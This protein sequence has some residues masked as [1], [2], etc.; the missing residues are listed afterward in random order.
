MSS[1]VDDKE[2]SPR[3]HPAFSYS[4]KQ[5]EPTVPLEA[6]SHWKNKTLG[7]ERL[8][9]TRDSDGTVVAK[10]LTQGFLQ[11]IASFF[12]SNK[13]DN[14][15]M[16]KD[17]KK[18]QHI[19]Q[20]FFEL[21]VLKMNDLYHKRNSLKQVLQELESD[22]KT[23]EENSSE[24]NT[25]LKP[26][27]DPSEQD[28]KHKPLAENNSYV[29]ELPNFELPK[30]SDTEIEERKRAITAMRKELFSLAKQIQ[31][32]ESSPEIKVYTQLQ[33][34]LSNVKKAA[35]SAFKI[36]NNLE[37][38]K[39]DPNSSPDLQRAMNDV[40]TLY[41]NFDEGV[42]RTL[43]EKS[44]QQQIN[45]FSQYVHLFPEELQA[46]WSEFL[47]ILD[48][49]PSSEA[50][51]AEVDGMIHEISKQYSALMSKT[52]SE[53]VKD[54]NIRKEILETQSSTKDA[55]VLKAEIHLKQAICESRRD[56]WE[57]IDYENEKAGFKKIQ[58]LQELIKQQQEVDKLFVRILNQE[59][60]V[61][62]LSKVS[63]SLSY[64]VAPL[65]PLFTWPVKEGLLAR[66]K[67]YDTTSLL[68]VEQAKEKLLTEIAEFMK[69]IPD[70]P[71]KN[72]LVEKHHVP[73]F[74]GKELKKSQLDAYV[75]AICHAYANDSTFA[76]IVTRIRA[77][78][79]VLS[80]MI[81]LQRNNNNIFSKSLQDHHS[82]IFSDESIRHTAIYKFAESGKIYIETCL[83]DDINLND[84]SNEW[85]K[86]RQ[87]AA[88]KIDQLIQLQ[89]ASDLYK[90]RLI[91]N[92]QYEEQIKSLTGPEAELGRTCLLKLES[93]LHSMDAS[94]SRMDKNLLV[95]YLTNFIAVDTQLDEL[96]STQNQRKLK[97]SELNQ[98]IDDFIGSLAK[99]DKC[100]ETIEKEYSIELKLKSYLESQKHKLRELK[101]IAPSTGYLSYL[102]SSDEKIEDISLDSLLKHIKYVENEFKNIQ[103]FLDDSKIAKIPD[104]ITTFNNNYSVLKNKIPSLKGELKFYKS[105]TVNDDLQTMLRVQ[106]EDFNTYPISEYIYESLKTDIEKLKEIA[107]QIS[108]N[109][110]LSLLVQTENLLK[111]EENLKSDYEIKLAHANK[112]NLDKEINIAEEARLSLEEATILAEQA[113]KSFFKQQADRLIRH[114][115][116]MTNAAKQFENFP[117]LYQQTISIIKRT[118]A[119]LDHNIQ[120]LPEAIREHAK[121][122]TPL[123]EQGKSPLSPN[124]NLPI[125]SLSIK[126]MQAYEAAID[127]VINVSGNHL[128]NLE[129]AFQRTEKADKQFAKKL[130]DLKKRTEDLDKANQL[131][132]RE[133]LK[134]TISKFEKSN[135]EFRAEV[136][137]E[138]SQ[139]KSP[140][141]WFPIKKWFT[142][143]K[144]LSPNNW[145][146][147]IT[148]QQKREI[149]PTNAFNLMEEYCDNIG[150]AVA[151][152]E[153]ELNNSKNFA[154]LEIPDQLEQC[155]DLEVAKELQKR[156]ND[157]IKPKSD[158]VR[159]KLNT[160]LIYGE[161]PSEL[162]KYISPT[163]ELYY[164]IRKS[165]EDK[166]ASIDRFEKGFENKNIFAWLTGSKT[167][168][169]TELTSSQMKSHTRDLKQIQT[170]ITSNI[171]DT[172]FI[173]DIVEAE[174]YIEEASTIQLEAQVAKL[175][176]DGF[177]IEAYE[178][179]QKIFKDMKPSS[180]WHFKGFTW[181]WTGREPNQK[182]TSIDDLKKLKKELEKVKDSIK[183]SLSEA[184]ANAKSKKPSPLEDQLRRLIKEQTRID[185]LVKPFAIEKKQLGNFPG[186]I[187]TLRTKII[188]KATN[189]LANHQSYLKKVQDYIDKIYSS[190]KID[191][192]SQKE[193]DELIK[194]EI[195]EFAA[196]NY[197]YDTFLPSLSLSQAF[198]SPRK[199][200]AD[201]TA[202]D[203]I[204]FSPDSQISKRIAASKKTIANIIDYES[205]NKV[206]NNYEAI[207]N[208]AEETKKTL[209]NI[210]DIY[211][212]EELENE[213]DLAKNDKIHT[214]S[215]S[216]KDHFEDLLD[217]LEELANNLE[218]REIEIGGRPPMKAADQILKISNP[219][220]KEELTRF[221]AKDITKKTIQQTVLI[222]NFNEDLKK[223]SKTLPGFPKE[224]KKTITKDLNDSKTKIEEVS[225]GLVEK[226][227]WTET[228]IP[229]QDLDING[230]QKVDGNLKNEFKNANNITDK[231]HLQLLKDPLKFYQERLEA[232]EKTKAKWTKEKYFD[233]VEELNQLIKKIDGDFKNHFD[234]A[235]LDNLPKEMLNLID[236]ISVKTSE[237]IDGLEKI[238]DKK[239]KSWGE[240]VQTR[241][242]LLMQ[243]AANPTSDDCKVAKQKFDEAITEFRTETKTK[244]ETHSK[245]IDEY[246]QQLDSINKTVQSALKVDIPAMWKYNAKK[247]IEQKKTQ[248]N[249]LIKG[250]P[251]IGEKGVTWKSF[252]MISQQDPKVA[253]PELK[254]YGKL[255]SSIAE[256]DEEIKITPNSGLGNLKHLFKFDQIKSDLDKF[257]QKS[258]DITRIID[259]SNTAN[260]SKLY[261]AAALEANTKLLKSSLQSME[262]PYDIQ[263]FTRTLEI[264]L[265]SVRRAYEEN[266]VRENAFVGENKLDPWSYIVHDEN[267]NKDLYR[268]QTEPRVEYLNQ[269][270][271]LG[272]SIT[273]NQNVPTLNVD[274][275]KTLTKNEQD[276]IATNKLQNETLLYELIKK[277]LSPNSITAKEIGSFITS[278]GPKLNDT[279]RSLEI[280]MVTESGIMPLPAIKLFA[281]L[282]EYKKQ[283]DKAVS[284]AEQEKSKLSNE[285]NTIFWFN[286]L[287]KAEQKHSAEDV[288]A[289]H[290][291][292]VL[293]YGNSNEP[294]QAPTVQAPVVPSVQP[295]VLPVFNLP[296]VRAT[297]ERGKFLIEEWKNKA[298]QLLT[299]ATMS[300]NKNSLVSTLRTWNNAEI[301]KD[302]KT[303]GKNLRDAFV[304]YVDQQTCTYKYSLKIGFNEAINGIIAKIEDTTD[305]S[306]V[307]QQIQDN[308]SMDTIT[309]IIDSLTRVQSRLDDLHNVFENLVILN[310]QTSSIREKI[311]NVLA[312]PQAGR[313]DDLNKQIEEAQKSLRDLRMPKLSNE[314]E[315]FN[316]NLLVLKNKLT[317]IN[318]DFCFY[319]K[320][321]QETPNLAR[322]VEVNLSTSEVRKAL[323]SHLH[324]P[325][326][327]LEDVNKKREHLSNFLDSLQTSNVIQ[328]KDNFSL[329]WKKKLF[330]YI[331]NLHQPNADQIYQNLL[332][333]KAI[334]EEID[335]FSQKFKDILINIKEIT[336]QDFSNYFATQENEIKNFKNRILLTDNDKLDEYKK[337]IT[338]GLKKI[339]AEL[340]IE[341]ITK[342]LQS[343]NNVKRDISS[344]RDRFRQDKHYLQTQ[345]L[346][347]VLNN[348]TQTQTSITAFDQLLKM[349]PNIPYISYTNFNEIS[350]KIEK[351]TKEL[352]EK[353]ESINKSPIKKTDVSQ[354]MQNASETDEEFINFKKEMLGKIEKEIL[355]IE[356]S[357]DFVVTLINSNQQ[358]PWASFLKEPVD[359]EIK[360]FKAQIN[361]INSPQKVGF[362]LGNPIP[363][364][365]LKPNQFFE[366]QQVALE[367]LKTA[368][369]RIKSIEN[370]CKTIHLSQTQLDDFENKTAEAKDSL[371]KLSIRKIRNFYY[372]KKIEVTHKKLKELGE[373]FKNFNWVAANYYDYVSPII[374]TAKE[375]DELSTLYSKILDNLPE[376][377]VTE[378]NQLKAASNDPLVKFEAND[379][380]FQGIK[381]S[382]QTRVNIALNKLNE[383]LS[384]GTFEDFNNHPQIKDL[385]IKAIKDKIS[386]VG[387]LKKDETQIASLNIDELAAWLGKIIGLSSANEAPQNAEKIDH[388]ADVDTVF[389]RLTELRKRSNKFKDALKDC[390]MSNQ[391]LK[392]KAAV[393]RD[394]LPRL[395]IEINKK[396]DQVL[397]IPVK[398]S[399]DITIDKFIDDFQI[400][401][402]KKLYKDYIDLTNQSKH[403]NYAGNIKIKAE[404][405][406]RA[407]MD[408]R[409]TMSLDAFWIQFDL[410]KINLQTNLRTNQMG[411][412]LP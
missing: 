133:K 318:N 389:Q 142:E 348:P 101:T 395:I 340:G 339:E 409:N 124:Q 66:K 397:S 166:I 179:E 88:D 37:I 388:K 277:G 43:E 364:E 362:G 351:V 91:I 307:Y 194:R 54:W 410:L 239:P 141:L 295:A 117:L 31:Q 83:T 349:T 153:R 280:G 63:S 146:S 338:K 177:F 189:D 306:A 62:L 377:M 301:Y 52:I 207:L 271:E 218:K 302:L 27:D 379:P 366:Y 42:K 127:L 331:Q 248:L 387:K 29:I 154:S 371:S 235:D 107:D 104:L 181:S 343:Y 176:N 78:K 298:N 180:G 67:Y 334:A 375:F 233:S 360:I 86:A 345:R 403:P 256:K 193:V 197:Q 241:G 323:D 47:K 319:E 140:S 317:K 245:D 36:L 200:L 326:I 333:T 77:E 266:N 211:Y 402:R 45:D 370:A 405:D 201:F 243:L 69:E 96:F 126:E 304:M 23:A 278:T 398:S 223:V 186:D 236:I 376:D 380:I 190:Y 212:A 125:H 11:R 44:L 253:L 160:L 396:I 391:E 412:S 352:K 214:T 175:K 276:S 40:R 374:K 4:T 185:S 367:T 70:S 320:L 106:R 381:N 358:A 378:F 204:N 260:T 237:L 68:F 208:K 254:L 393:A 308:H 48:S 217:R 76:E 229:L 135:K 273:Y 16:I 15:Y 93:L 316:Q 6:K 329:N 355:S 39:E 216:D 251:T 330:E 400:K 263:A 198:S 314:L 182:A 297:N 222:D 293:P 328:K 270:R 89:P 51:L 274:S 129:K 103:A 234:K 85:Q 95:S 9:I 342:A 228:F 259:N 149:I 12:G 284:N 369:D 94:I 240:I 313:K 399:T 130:F 213:I 209:I 347:N 383:L 361:K 337:V 119:V 92:Q 192:I 272:Y 65:K 1:F 283:I 53:I 335:T 178:L 238:S 162:K 75:E 247:H 144:L 336:G 158:E 275:L 262:N 28:N 132:S 73:L 288:V 195:K 173:S 386:E 285:N 309:K 196:A 90:E 165:I 372:E 109:E 191:F 26:S 3:L 55:N 357:F 408:K 324:N 10:R 118:K 128:G 183:E 64:L 411:G 269:I 265:A 20:D 116:M 289:S 22:L 170:S 281:H 122:W 382:T 19:P 71:V 230:L 171:N 356:E 385:F 401:N 187:A 97:I 242:E 206:Q 120:N 268:G 188:N 115:H 163:S 131:L 392:D 105:K 147:L 257:H 394:S 244:L 17:E 110:T 61:S 81:A 365:N 315:P 123:L 138:K 159:T 5:L 282:S 169:T 145:L 57:M 250:L 225:S 368:K 321:I 353:F 168:P 215:I 46:K 267:A 98:K 25:L 134:K 38:Y 49:K 322:K 172:L 148:Q 220:K 286:K 299:E 156:F 79:E 390:P 121:T 373:K 112:T 100:V 136:S 164:E 35:T 21:E 312:P 287:A 255:V 346:S 143:G 184:K 294:V 2:K 139:L 344:A 111:E 113:R 41:T 167:I 203:I 384:A 350:S 137:A 261:L 258:V 202:M 82:Q 108:K 407:L 311:N 404:E 210:G 50:S 305:L 246:Y 300:Q 151:E 227:F 8:V 332:N 72:E 24:I 174:K 327:S 249:D 152:I 341:G 279:L 30:V 56:L 226:G 99:Y 32:Q 325:A 354:Y 359:E 224:W 13:A 231:Y 33:N 80:T 199:C 60:N 221:Y 84:L 34:S 232:I 205:F 155:Q 102:I 114:A 161:L 18:F 303:L 290:N 406:Y 264:A 74:T 14:E 310:Q 291:I 7:R 219:E 150:R 296:E 157:W 252:D 292:H 58:E 87:H 59:E 363:I